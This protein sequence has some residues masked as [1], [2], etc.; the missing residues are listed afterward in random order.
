MKTQSIIAASRAK[1]DVELN[2]IDGKIPKD[3]HGLVYAMSPSGTTNSNGLPYPEYYPDKEYNREY[4]S[5]I[6]NGDGV[7]LCL[8]FNNSS[9][10]R[11]K[12]DLM[13][14]PCFYADEATGRNGALA[15]KK[16]YWE[17]RF[18]N[19]GIARMSFGIGARNELN[20]AVVP[21]IR[22]G[23]KTAR[24]LA[25]YDV[26]RPFEFDPV[27]FKLTTPVGRNSDWT[28]ATPA[29]MNGAFPL[30][31]GTAHPSFDP[32][33]NE[34][35]VTN[36]TRGMKNMLSSIHF[37]NS[38]RKYPELIEQDLEKHLEAHRDVGDDEFIEKLDMFYKNAHEKIHRHKS[39]IN[40]AFDKMEH[41]MLE[42]FSKLKQFGEKIIPGNEV[43]LMKWDA[44]TGETLKWKL[45]DENNKDLIIRQ[46][47][48]QTGF[49]KDY[50]ILMD[51]SFKFN[52]DGLI[53]NPFPHN[54]KIDEL[55]RERTARPMAPRTE[56]FLVNRSDLVAGKKEV[57]VK[58][59]NPSLPLECI[60][61]SANYENPDNIITFYTA[62][63]SANCVAEWLRPYDHLGT[64]NNQP[65]EKD[66][67]GMLA[68][69]NM[70]VCR[71]G[72]FV[73]D[74]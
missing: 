10:V 23:E 44:N 42:A 30:V 4:G 26:G 33:T 56:T 72:K 27:T 3:I 50:V 51:S 20:T 34:L 31:E 54:A 7:V 70:D 65:I 24:L 69:G 66:L 22:K 6:M 9:G 19:M 2:V 11:L 36:Y 64:D 38:M 5:H 8:D 17:Y 39:F 68:S 35:F 13:K 49:T 73:V 52:M 15:D 53:S 21:F 57:V 16:R 67:I 45:V 43:F 28:A 46:C 41:A 55:I 60:H 59:L 37:F 1:L 14:T 29:F 18:H 32:N 48:H 58:T 62:D 12:T 74:A 71:V 63:N 25:T 40:R 47:M 61:F